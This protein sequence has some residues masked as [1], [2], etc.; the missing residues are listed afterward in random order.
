MFAVSGRKFRLGLSLA[1]TFALLFSIYAIQ[2]RLAYADG[3]FMEQFNASL[4]GRDA[5]LSVSVN[6]PILTSATRQDA[7]VQFRLYDANSNDTIKYSTFAIT[8]EKGAGANAQML[9]RE[10]FH[11]ESGLLTL[12]IQPQEGPVQFLGSQEGYI[13][14]WV[15]DPAGN[16]GVRGPIFLEGGL[17]HF[18]IEILG[19][20]SIRSLFPPDQITRFD[21]WLSVGDVFSQTVSFNG[22]NYNTTI[23]SY[24]DRVKEFNFDAASK[25]YSWVMPF[26]WNTSRIDKTTIF[27]HEE[28]K[29]PKAMQ[30]IGDSPAF[31]A[32][33]NNIPIKGA[34]LVLDPY[35]S[36][37]DLILHYLL[38]KPDVLAIAGQVPN[39]S[40]QMTF[41]LTPSAE[42]EA[43]TT[44][45]TSTDTG[46]I[47]VAL[48]WSPDPLNADTASTLNMIFSDAF[49]GKRFDNVD[50][51]YGFRILDKDGKE[52][53]TKQDLTAKGGTDTQTV[54][55]PSNENYRIEIKVNGISDDGRPVDK[56][57][58]G[59]AR[60]LVIVPE[61]PAGMLLAISGAVAS[62]IVLQRV[63]RGE[64]FLKGLKG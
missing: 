38:N 46:G 35:S 64:G 14:A 23:I 8:I 9:L 32:T 25:T 42:V 41:T 27:V 58:N 51:L 47:H 29:I 55:F 37:T 57:R 16:L 15:A 43:E 1:V 48:Q 17:Y 52:V 53:Y 22:N 34:K 21:S 63:A 59:I 3:L 30:S 12:R 44:T 7:Y 24:Y 13:N 20:D 56:T 49:S 60:G 26:D 19:I 18:G 36:E 54:D 45:E 40:D 5:R 62:V 2:P 11:T 10:V 28:V 33:V 4:K 6:P 61:F 39:G 31:K 50:I